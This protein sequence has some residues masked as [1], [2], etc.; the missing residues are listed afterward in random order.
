MGRSFRELV[1]LFPVRAIS[2][3]KEKQSE[4]RRGC[5]WRAQLLLQD[6]LSS[7]GS[8]GGYRSWSSPALAW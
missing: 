4:I 1:F 7:V 5:L 3:P 6:P 8:G 2:L